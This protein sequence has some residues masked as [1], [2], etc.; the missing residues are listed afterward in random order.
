MKFENLKCIDVDVNLDD[1]LKLYDYVRSNMEFPHWLGTFTLEEI[2]DILNYGGKIWL[3]Y[4]NNDL[5]CSVFYIPPSQRTLDKR[6]IKTKEIDT[7]SLGPIMV[8]P[9]YVGNGFM[10][11]MLQVFD[12]YCISI[13]KKYVFTKVHSDN[14][15]SINNM[16]K[17]GYDLVNEYDSDRGKTSVFLK[18]LFKD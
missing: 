4:N 15:Y 3:Y 11:K 12:R 14:I 6:G 9:D 10:S 13:N 16:Y 8:S 17:D 18:K 1:Y 2:K 5:V 7:G